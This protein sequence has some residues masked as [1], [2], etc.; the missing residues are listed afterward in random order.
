VKRI[1]EVGTGKKRIEKV[2]SRQRPA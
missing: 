1:V 2:T